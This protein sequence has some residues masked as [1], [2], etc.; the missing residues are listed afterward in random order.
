[1]VAAGAPRVAA[2]AGAMKG[3]LKGVEAPGADSGGTGVDVGARVV[4][5]N[6]VAAATRPPTNSS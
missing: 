1:M 2:V 4:A 6:A 3:E 5:V